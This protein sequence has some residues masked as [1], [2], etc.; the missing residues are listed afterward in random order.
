LPRLI[1]D[2]RITNL[3]QIGFLSHERRSSLK[4]RV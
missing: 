3:R 1:I 2:G 4:F